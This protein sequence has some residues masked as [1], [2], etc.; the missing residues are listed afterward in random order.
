MKRLLLKS[1]V[2]LFATL[3]VAAAYSDVTSLR[4][5]SQIIG[6]RP[7]ALGGAFTAVADD[8]NALFYNPAGLA[9]LDSSFAALLDTTLSGSAGSGGLTSIL[10]DVDATTPLIQKLASTSDLSTQIDAFSKIG[11]II[12]SRTVAAGGKTQSYW[13]SPGWGMAAT[14]GVDLGLGVHAKLVP[15]VADFAVLADGDFRFGYARKF[16]D[17]KMSAGIAPYYRLRGQGGRANLSLKDA[18]SKG[19]SLKNILGIGQGLGLDVGFM[20][21]PVEA[22]SP[23]FGLAI[24]NV[25]D[26]KLYK[27]GSSLFSN[28][29]F[30]KNADLVGAPDL[31]KQ[32]VNVGFSLSPID[33]PGFVRLSAEMKEINRPSA[34]ELKPAFGI[35]G[36]FRSR[37]VRAL[38]DAG[39]GNGG[40]SAGVE[41]RSFVKL[42]L[43]TYVEPNLFFDRKENQ[44][45]WMFSLGI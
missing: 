15:E 10:D 3:P 9:H 18:D 27:T 29:G 28:V 12:S 8:Q 20:V 30:L 23:T 5:P 37:F 44:R 16:L 34:A 7:A 17:G 22:M 31:I 43:A 21:T 25:G 39:W 1:S 32:V 2:G 11:E 36:G 19:D 45:I 14:L 38:V 6:A 40:W 26:T 13:A 24:L 33:G 4:L 35:E 42:R 41:L